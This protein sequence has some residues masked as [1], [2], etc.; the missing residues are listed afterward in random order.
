MEKLR[1]NYR[2]ILASRSPR[3]RSLLESC[4][5][6]FTVCPSSIRE[7]DFPVI[8][9]REYVK[10]LACAKAC[11]VADSCPESWVI[12]ADSIVLAEGSIL[13]K[14]G[15]A[16]AARDMLK[17]L[18]GRTHRVFTGY[19][20]VCREKEHCFTD[21]AETAV[22]FKELSSGEIEWYIKTKEPYDKAGG[23]AVQGLA[24]FMVQAVSGSY[25]NVVG[26]PLCEVVDHLLRHGVLSPGPG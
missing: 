17:T 25:T 1:T 16:E 5:I 19:S 20:V 21:A 14:P 23:Y 2:L 18:S 10:T 6:E 7:S 4:G 3:R 11:D 13:E 24:A 22:K 12:G 15:S 9:P 26:L 8:E